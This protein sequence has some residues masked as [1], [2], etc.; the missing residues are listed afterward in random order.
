MRSC[1]VSSLPRENRWIEKAAVGS[2]LW[3]Q[4]IVLVIVLVLVLENSHATSNI[5]DFEDEDE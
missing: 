3:H 1:F 2:G 4:S 5:P